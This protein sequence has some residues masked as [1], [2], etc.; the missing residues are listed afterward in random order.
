M[1]LKHA[2]ERVAPSTLISTQEKGDALKNEQQLNDATKKWRTAWDQKNMALLRRLALDR[3]TRKTFKAELTSD[4]ALAFLYKNDKNPQS[5]LEIALANNDVWLVKRISNHVSL[6]DR[7]SYSCSFLYSTASIMAL[8]RPQDS[9]LSRPPYTDAGKKYGRRDKGLLADAFYDHSCDNCL[10]VSEAEMCLLEKRM[11]HVDSR[12]FFLEKLIDEKLKLSSAKNGRKDNKKTLMHSS[13][14]ENV[15]QAIYGFLYGGQYYGKSGLP[16]NKV[17]EEVLNGKL[18]IAIENHSLAHAMLHLKHGASA[19]DYLVVPLLTGWHNHHRH[20][21]LFVHYATE[22]HI[23]DVFQGLLACIEKTKE[24]FLIPRQPADSPKRPVQELERPRINNASELFLLLKK[25]R[26]S[27]NPMDCYAMAVVLEGDVSTLI[28][29][30]KNGL[31]AET[32][33]QGIRAIDKACSMGKHEHA[34]ALV[35]YGADP[36]VQLVANF[37][38]GK[39]T[40][41]LLLWAIENNKYEDARMLLRHGA[42]VQAVDGPLDTLLVAF[43]AGDRYINLLSEFNIDLERPIGKNSTKPETLFD[44]ATGLQPIIGYQL[45]G[46]GMQE[47]RAKALA[48]QQAI[49]LAIAIFRQRNKVSEQFGVAWLIK[50]L[51]YDAIYLKGVLNHQEKLNKKGLAE[52]LTHTTK[53]N[54]IQTVFKTDELLE[55]ALFQRKPE[56]LKVLLEHGL[57]LSRLNEKRQKAL[58]DYLITKANLAYLKQLCEKNCKALEACLDEENY[59]DYA[60]KHNKKE[61]ADLLFKYGV[62]P[63]KNMDFKNLLEVDSIYLKAMLE[64]ELLTAVLNKK[65]A[66][67]KNLL[68]L[69]IEQGKYDHAKAIVER[70]Y[71]RIFGIE[72]CSTGKTLEYEIIKNDRDAKLLDVLIGS[73]CKL[74]LNDFKE[75]QERNNHLSNLLHWA[76]HFERLEHIKCLAQHGAHIGEN[77]I[78]RAVSN[79]K[80][81]DTVLSLLENTQCKMVALNQE[82]ELDRYRR[83]TMAP[84]LTLNLNGLARSIANAGPKENDEQIRL[85]HEYMALIWNVAAAHGLSINIPLAIKK[86]SACPSACAIM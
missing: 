60:L 29:L 62:R 10:S 85:R 57:S 4:E 50:L 79:F 24:D 40:I 45:R 30:L 17:Q 67:N 44:F 61:A 46:S 33:I 1:D 19:V 21:E 12:W 37:R 81:P 49:N 55:A 7:Q 76:I 43:K 32:Y 52:N 13:I 64:Q 53:R 70:G 77:E 15:L 42:K 82:Q 74:S 2:H 9:A 22:D 14:D 56:H 86:P 8:L 26:K 5:I 16:V 84:D 59:L 23:R 66:D 11:T 71:S 69:A 72:R 68:E 34:L 47:E 48:D 3:V 39:E 73:F 63:T 78:W 35:Q 36:N 75:I 27:I 20:M 65:I 41:P 83:R 80:N 18:K 58:R 28:N 25:K 54:E 31:D 51:N 38:G 6:K